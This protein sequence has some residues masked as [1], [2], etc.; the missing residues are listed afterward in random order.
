MRTE[1]RWLLAG[2]ALL[3][4]IGA[5]P[6]P[7]ALELGSRLYRGEAALTAR[8]TGHTE[9]LPLEA[10]RCTNCH[11]RESQP[12]VEPAT[13]NFGPPLGGGLARPTARR[14][15]PPSRYDAKALCRL[16]RDGIDPAYVMIPQTMPRYTMNDRECEALWAFLTAP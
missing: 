6:A 3:G 12:P 9:T 11:R 4:S 15:G 2:V 5:A 16:L 10:V 8:M 1:L 7:S 13:E 14:G